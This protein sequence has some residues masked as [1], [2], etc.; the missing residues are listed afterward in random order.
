M[1]G[2]NFAYGSKC[3]WDRNTEVGS[4]HPEYFGRTYVTE[5]IDPP[6]DEACLP[7]LRLAWSQSTRE[8]RGVRRQRNSTQS[9][10]LTH[11]AYYLLVSLYGLFRLTED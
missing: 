9:S 1:S 11:P 5:W 6:I 4:H 2:F 8:K 10:S 3:V 7:L